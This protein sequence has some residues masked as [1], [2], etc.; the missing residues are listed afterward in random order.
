MK[1]F[2]WGRKDE[3]L[4]AP[5]LCSTRSPSGALLWTPLKNAEKRA[6]SALKGVQSRPGSSLDL[7]LPGMSGLDLMIRE[8]R[9]ARGKALIPFLILTARG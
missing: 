5:P 8:I 7:G 9:K 6:L 4:V 2:G 3:C 1:L